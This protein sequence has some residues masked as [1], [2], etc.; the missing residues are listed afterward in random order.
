MILKTK[1]KRHK[2]IR[3][4]SIGSVSSWIN[5]KESLVDTGE[6]TNRIFNLKKKIIIF[7]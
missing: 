3:S 5:E 2:Q 4:I 7:P 6:V 1:N